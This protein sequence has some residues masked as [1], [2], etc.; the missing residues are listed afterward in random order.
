MDLLNNTAARKPLSAVLPPLVLGTAAFNH[1]Y[2]TDPLSLPSTSII[3]RALLSGIRAFDTSP[4]YGP[5]ESLL[6][7]ALQSQSHISRS[8]YILQTKCGRISAE[9]FD[10][11]PEWIRKSVYRSLERLGTKYL[12]VVFC[13]D[14]EFVDPREVVPAVQTLR[15][16][17]DIGLIRY[18]GISGYPTATLATL[19]QRVTDETGEPLDVVMNYAQYTL[20]NTTLFS[21]GLKKLV[22]AGVDCVL[23]G[24]PL[25][26]GLLRGQGV[27]V[28]DM[29]DFHP[30]PTALREKC[31][32][33]SFAVEKFGGG[34]ESLETLALRFSM[35]GWSR[36]GA[37]AG[38][39]VHPSIEWR[40]SHRLTNF[41]QPRVGISVAG[42]SFMHELDSL[43]VI[44]KDVAL[45]LE[46][47]YLYQKVAD[48]LGDGWRDYSWAS[49]GDGFSRK[50]VVT[51]SRI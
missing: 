17:R 9:K 24:S 32:D 3:H 50:D 39:T 44:W 41:M 13:H 6:G 10:Y 12:D 47:E 26:M 2:N 45:T 20:Q 28:G 18:V 51:K 5:A 36:D 30:A 38:T 25:G 42:V 37:V 8:E 27:P 19:A 43:L 4:Y 31:A 1:Q 15:E 29:G 46:R 16:L 7:Q 33:A 21:Q 49:P 40:G 22:E 14:V 35:E 23:N 48:V 11:S 34:N